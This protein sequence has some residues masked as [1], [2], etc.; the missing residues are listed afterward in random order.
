MVSYYAGEKGLQ[1]RLNTDIEIG[2]PLETY[3]VN[4]SWAIESK[5]LSEEK[6]RLKTSPS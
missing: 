2:L 4:E 1:V 3:V 6:E 5:D